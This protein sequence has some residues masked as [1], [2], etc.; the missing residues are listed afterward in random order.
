MDISDENYSILDSYTRGV[1]ER[2]IKL[3]PIIGL[4][5]GFTLTSAK[6]L[7]Y[8]PETTT[9]GVI[10][11]DAVC[12]C[13]CLIAWFFKHM[14]IERN[15]FVDKRRLHIVKCSLVA[16]TWVQWNLVTYIFP[17]GDFWGYAALFIL[18]PAFFFDSRLMLLEIAGITA[19]A[20]DSWIIKGGVLL[21]ARDNSF[22]LNICL[23]LLS[24]V[25]TFICIYLITRYGEIFKNS[26]DEQTR[27]LRERNENLDTLNEDI[28]RFTADI[29]E[30][31]DSCSGSHIKRVE[32]YV[33]I[34]TDYVFRSY[35]EY[36]L[37]E[38]DVNLISKASVLH[39]VGKIHISDSILL[40][41]G[42]LTEEEF[43][44]IKKHTLFGAHIVDKM[45]Q[46]MNE[47][48]RKHCRDICLYHHERVNGKGYPCGLAGNDI[49]VS[50]QVVAMLDCF[51]ALTTER[52]YK[53]ALP[54]DR[55][56]EMIL[57]G[58]CGAFS[59]KMLTAFSACRDELTE[60]V[61]RWL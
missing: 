39:D 30:E 46:G 56:F 31:R 22:Y 16:L 12:L 53:A 55:A 1:F 52:P 27:L 21:P 37:T 61:A 36:G 25:L 47:Q 40:K 13:F 18:L 42:K 57:N 28:I 59:E 2:I 3:A 14:G 4:S 32:E 6:L 48:F 11:F 15:G 54:A 29:V 9:T 7:G 50:A 35:P 17:T 58:E 34:L 41:P 43:E 26:A 60:A 33:Y 8:Y 20:V 19:S 23:R 44:T 38:E 49:P 5:A 10:C 51:D 45:P 24:Y